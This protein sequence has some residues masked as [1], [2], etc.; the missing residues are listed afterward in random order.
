[1]FSFSSC[2]LTLLVADSRLDTR[3]LPRNDSSDDAVRRC[4]RASGVAED[5]RAAEEVTDG[6]RLGVAEGVAKE[7]RP[8]IA[9]GAVEDSS[10]RVAALMTEPLG[11]MLRARVDRAVEGTSLSLDTLLASDMADDG[12]TTLGVAK[13]DDSRR[14]GALAAGV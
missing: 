11:R 8:F 1:M 3:P 7:V 6:V 5:G 2:S 13:M 10:R 4:V 9:E 12:R 14:S